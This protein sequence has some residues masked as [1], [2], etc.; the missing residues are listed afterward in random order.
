MMHPPHPLL[1]R[2]DLFA[3]HRLNQIS[4][5]TDVH[6]VDFYFNAR[7]AL[8]HLFTRLRTSGRSR[9][10][11]PAFHC[12]SMVDPAVHAG[13]EVDFYHV[14]RRLRVD[15][16]DFM[17]RV[18]HDVAA[19]V[20]VNYFG[21]PAN[22]EEALPKLHDMGIAS[23][24]DCSHSFVDC[25]RFALTGNRGDHAVF[26]FAKLVPSTYG[27]GLRS[28][29]PGPMPP[30]RPLP[31]RT[32]VLNTK[33]MLEQL[34]LTADKGSRLKRAYLQLEDYRIQLKSWLESS[35]RPPGEHSV[36]SSMPKATQ[37]SMFDINLAMAEMPRLSRW[38]LR[39]A[40]LKT[41]AMRRRRNYMI[42]AEAL[43]DSPG[44]IS[45][46]PRLADGVCPWAYPILLADRPRRDIALRALGVPVWTFGDELHPRLASGGKTVAE[47]DARYLAAHLL[48]LPVHQG[49]APEQVERFAASVRQSGLQAPTT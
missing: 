1:R 35:V 7:S 12:T 29:I 18:S 17:C 31:W 24:E 27:G 48:C 44:P 43:A 41:I 33:R 2:E 10:L 25:D 15:I 6:Q 23:I 4:S 28:R 47:T 39:R 32:T 46:A 3:G 22:L 34:I 5:L 21:F 36:P 45:V 16:D 20:F 38:I 19:A 13:F 42:Y 11:L 8:Y 40:D 37:T 30:L 9:V 49:L 26:S 14:N